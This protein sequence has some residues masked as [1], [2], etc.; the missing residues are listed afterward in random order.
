MRNPVCLGPQASGA[1]VHLQLIFWAM[2]I[3]LGRAA[4]KFSSSF[5]GQRRQVFSS[6]GKKAVFLGSLAAMLQWES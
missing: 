2:A 5:N 1:C 3:K 6:S 4:Y